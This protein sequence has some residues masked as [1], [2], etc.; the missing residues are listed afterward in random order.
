MGIKQKMWLGICAGGFLG[1]LAVGIVGFNKTVLAEYSGP[2]EPYRYKLERELDSLSVLDMY[3]DPHTKQ[4][5][6]ELINEY[7]RLRAGAVVT[8]EELAYE[9]AHKA[10]EDGL[11]RTARY[12]IYP[13]LALFAISLAAVY[14]SI[15]GLEPGG[16]DC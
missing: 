5:Y 15:R 9:T 13:G 1:S 2:Q 6:L 11:R 16:G 3:K 14:L 10:Y 4:K 7:E 12:Y 8:R